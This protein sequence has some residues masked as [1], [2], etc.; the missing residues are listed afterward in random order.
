M[1]PSDDDDDDADD[2][3]DHDDGDD[4]GGGDD[5]RRGRGRQEGGREER[6]GGAGSREQGAGRK[7]GRRRA[8]CA[9]L[10]KTRTPPSSPRKNEPFRDRGF[11]PHRQ[12]FFSAEPFRPRRF[13]PPSQ[14]GTLPPQT[15]SAPQSARNPSA[16]DGF[17]PSQFYQCY[18]LKGQPD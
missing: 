17:P 9:V 13:P 6:R 18:L 14:C 1:G 16:P 8:R 5:E 15:V 11:P 2:D 7:E 3:D 12:S 4:D 10:F